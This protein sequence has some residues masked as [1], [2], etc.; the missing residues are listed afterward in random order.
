ML[1]MLLLYFASSL[2]LPVWRD[3]GCN[4]IEEGADGKTV[5]GR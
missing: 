4:S 5:V 2:H 1:R 3:G